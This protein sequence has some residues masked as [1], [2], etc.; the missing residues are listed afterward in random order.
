MKFSSKN[1]WFAICQILIVLAVV[2]SHILPINGMIKSYV[3][4]AGTTGAAFAI[5][6]SIRSSRRGSAVRESWDKAV[7]FTVFMFICHGGAL[8]FSLPRIFSN[9]GI[10]PFL[11]MIIPSLA[12][13]IALPLLLV[14]YKKHLFPINEK[15]EKLI[16]NKPPFFPPKSVVAI[17][18]KINL[19]E[20]HIRSIQER[21]K[22]ANNYIRLLNEHKGVPGAEGLIE[23]QK[24][25]DK[26]FGANYA[27]Y[28]SLN[29]HIRFQFYVML[30]K[31][32]IL[33]GK[34]LHN[35]DIERFIE[36]V[37][38]DLRSRMKDLTDNKNPDAAGTMEFI[39]L[40]ESMKAIEKKISHIT[41]DLISA[42]SSEIIAGTSP[43][44]EKNLLDIYK[45]EYDF[46]AALEHLRK[47]DDEHDRFM[48]EKELSDI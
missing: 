7:A 17:Y 23:K 10:G 24:E 16:L 18:Q 20:D 14:K 28:C 41:S 3:I 42:Q 46:E 33:P 39:E 34:I 15:I 6:L 12:C 44:D 1:A 45:Q 40:N 25:Y 36:A 48:A 27:E 31:E 5:S 22:A 35:L 32:I 9:L 4:L 13:W 29:L 8:L 30:I 11:M 2:F 43:I 26:Y 37:K 19:I 21:S 47:S 38:T